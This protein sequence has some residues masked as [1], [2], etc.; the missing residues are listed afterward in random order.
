MKQRVSSF[1]HQQSI[2]R[3]WGDFF[4]ALRDIVLA[5]PEKSLPFLFNLAQYAFDIPFPKQHEIQAQSPHTEFLLVVLGVHNAS[6]SCF[7][8]VI[9]FNRDT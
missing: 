3:V 1:Q 5:N 7:S 9:S 2:R 4:I 6:I 8:C